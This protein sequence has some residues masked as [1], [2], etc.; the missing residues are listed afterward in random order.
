VA[1]G[2][3]RVVYIE[4][5]PKSLAQ[6]LYLDSIKIGGSIDARKVNFRSFVGVAPARYFD[7]FE[8]RT[9]RKDRK[10]N[11]VLWNKM[12]AIP[13]IGNKD[14]TLYLKREV[15]FIK[16]TEQKMEDAAIKPIERGAIQ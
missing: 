6:D 9:D 3:M 15:E 7:F 10:G 16:W 14:H 12:L 2:V 13:K 5:Y 8:A 4:P 11:A 1:A